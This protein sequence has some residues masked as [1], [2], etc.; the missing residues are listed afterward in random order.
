MSALG[1][2]INFDGLYQP[3]GAR[4]NESRFTKALG[5][6]LDNGWSGDWTCSVDVTTNLARSDTT[7]VPVEAR[8]LP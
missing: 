3:S 8:K 6:V 5:S 2:A 1:V 7:V 4:C